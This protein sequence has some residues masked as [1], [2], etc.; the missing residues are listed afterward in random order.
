M[1]P[2]WKRGSCN[3]ADPEEFF[4]PEGPSGSRMLPKRQQEIIDT[5]CYACPIAAEC[6][7]FGQANSPGYGIWGGQYLGNRPAPKDFTVT[8]QVMD[9][10]RIPHESSTGRALVPCGTPAAVRRHVRHGEPLDPACAE[11]KN[12]EVRERYTRKREAA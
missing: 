7:A 10:V 12:R 11:V 8:R 2:D 4:P 9:L 5:Y 6:L 3:G 1:T